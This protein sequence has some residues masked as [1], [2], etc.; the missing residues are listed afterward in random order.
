MFRRPAAPSA[1]VPLR[2]LTLGRYLAA[3][4]ALLRGAALP[5]LDGVRVYVPVEPDP[6]A[7]PPAAL[8]DFLDEVLE[9]PPETY[10]DEAALRALA[11]AVWQAVQAA[12]LRASE[13][14]VGRAEFVE[15]YT[16]HYLSG[17]PDS[18]RA[19]PPVEHMIGQMEPPHYV[20]IRDLPLWEGLL[21][22]RCRNVILARDAEDR[23]SPHADG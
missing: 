18:E 4:A 17:G 14:A 5:E 7:V 1:G 13:L 15:A 10:A 19:E 22:L 8:L 2:P 16:G 3:R 20:A 12:A 23:K 9:S 21:V 6:A 11:G